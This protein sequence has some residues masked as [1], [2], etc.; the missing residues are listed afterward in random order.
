MTTT[1]RQDTVPAGTLEDGR[2]VSIAGPTLTIPRSSGPVPPSVQ[3]T[4]GAR[5]RDGVGNVAAL[6]NEEMFDR[7]DRVVAVLRPPVL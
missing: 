2:V 7:P 3:E 6:L 5:H 1:A 4:A